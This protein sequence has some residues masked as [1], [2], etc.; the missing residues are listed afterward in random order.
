MRKYKHTDTCTYIYITAN[1][2]YT[3]TLLQHLHGRPR[4]CNGWLAF[5]VKTKIEKISKWH[6]Q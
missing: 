5:I 3:H 2:E 6:K 4:T 1:P